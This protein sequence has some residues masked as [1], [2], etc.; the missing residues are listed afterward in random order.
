MEF[1]GS[2]FNKISLFVTK[3]EVGISVDT[4]SK[5]VKLRNKIAHGDTVD[6]QNLTNCLGQCE[7]LAMQMFSKQQKQHL[8]HLE[9]V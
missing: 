7:Y 2:I 9:K 4:I 6:E 1:Y 3:E 5:L 8:L